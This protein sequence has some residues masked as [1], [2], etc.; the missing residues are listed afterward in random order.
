V[1]AKQLAEW[2]LTQPAH[3]Q[4][5]SVT[6][7]VSGSL[8]TAKRVVAYETGSDCG[9]YVEPMGT[10]ARNIAGAKYPSHIDAYGHVEPPTP[11]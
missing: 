6:G 9:I 7:V 5:G 11:S 1:T 8:F 3:I 2:I 4:N 10:H